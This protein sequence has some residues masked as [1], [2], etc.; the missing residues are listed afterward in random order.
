MPRLRIDV[1][2]WLKAA[3]QVQ[4][5]RFPVLGRQIDVDVAVIGGGITGAA[6]AWR[7]AKAGVSVAL[8]E[9]RRVGRGSTSA[10]TALLM[11]EP[12]ED[13]AVLVE[14]YGRRRAQRIWQLSREATNEFV[15]TLHRLAIA[16]DLRRRDSVYYATTAKDAR[17]LGA[18]H[19]Q[20][21]D[22][23]V[24]GR[25]LDGA[26]LRRTLGFDAVAAIRTRGNA[27][28]DPYKASLGLIRAAAAE[29]AKVFERSPVASIRPSRHDVVLRTPRGTIRAERVIIATGYA[30]PYFKTLDARFRML[31]TYVVATRPLTLP[32]RRRVGLDAVML[33]DM[34]RPYHYARWTPDHRLILGGGDRP[35]GPERKRLKA[36]AEGT[37]AVQ[38]HFC[39]LYRA[40]T[41]VPFEYGWEGLFATT[42][43]GLPYIG[44]HR[45]YG[46]HLFALGYGGNGMTM[47]FLAARLL[48]DWYRG[49]KS[50]DLDLFAFSR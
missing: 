31:T 30:T 22:A 32:E 37:S 38:D 8:V 44:P 39:A 4:G 16:C 34:E 21:T 48:L 14:R 28:V 42:P 45:R 43:D 26:V 5:A 7:F 2:L 12:D 35:L 19:R 6:V 15:E 41:D 27:Q 33:W 46:R 10:S 36:L 29:G 3:A 49:E 18:E 40:L 24:R 23:G 13:L 25:W 17:R 1:P 11:Q 50:A 20:R 47:G 9:G